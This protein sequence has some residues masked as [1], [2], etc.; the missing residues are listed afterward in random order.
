MPTFNT[1]DGFVNVDGMIIE[2]DVYEIGKELQEIDENLFIIGVDPDQADFTDAPYIIA[3]LCPDG[4]YRRI[5]EVWQLD[6][7]VIDRVRAA[8]TH[9]NDIQA[10]LDYI[11]AKAKHEAAQRFKEKQ[12]EYRDI[13]VG[14]LKNRKSTYT[15]RDPDTSDLVKIYEDR[16]SERKTT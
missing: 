7:S 15:Y 14:V 2:R 16:P 10:H 4:Q 13:G 5:F 9:A 3:E 6:R 11:N 8:D 12:L 1:G